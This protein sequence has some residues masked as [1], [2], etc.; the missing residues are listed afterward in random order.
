MQAA[1]TTM[2]SAA[3]R[4]LVLNPNTSSAF[5]EKI[6]RVA[7]RCA[8]PDAVE[9]ETAQPKTGP[10]SIESVYDELLSAVPSLEAYLEHAAAR[11][12]DG[13]VVACFSDHPV[14]QAL[15]EVG[16][17]AAVVGLLD[18]SLA[19]ASL[20]GDRVGIVTTSAGWEPLLRS[21]VD[22]LGYGDRCRQIVAVGAP[23]LA[24]E[25]DDDEVAGRVCEAAA[26][27]AASSDVVIL[28]CAGMGPLATRVE[29]ALGGAAAVVEPVEAAVRACAS[30]ALQGLGSSAA[31]PL[32]QHH[33]GPL[34]PLLA[35]A[36]ASRGAAPEAPSPEAPSP[37]VDDYALSYY[38]DY[39]S[40]T[41]P[42]TPP[43]TT[44]PPPSMPPG[45]DDGGDVLLSF[46]DYVNPR[47]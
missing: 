23:V 33:A 21:G 46:D 14:Q 39:A 28:G 32:F 34:S 6:A 38:D 41:A 24:L 43:P 47:S 7:A 31:R 27:V 22:R 42:S 12:I 35:G 10:R 37:A 36:Y 4:L 44:R 40:P 25:G 5:T 29:A 3:K 15:R 30:L 19:A 8:I 1:L 18:A 20:A 11:R 26:R 13:V 17:R 16:G 2:A 9:I 45:L